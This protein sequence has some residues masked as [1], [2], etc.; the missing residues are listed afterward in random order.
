MSDLDCTYSEAGGGGISEIKK[1]RI[2]VYLVSI[3]QEERIDQ[4][5]YEISVD[6]ACKIKILKKESSTKNFH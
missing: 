1:I 5:T 2:N 4:F 6:E 3:P